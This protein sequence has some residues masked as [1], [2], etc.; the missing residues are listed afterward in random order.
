MYRR[1]DCFKLHYMYHSIL[2]VS[3]ICMYIFA[4]IILYVHVFICTITLYIHVHVYT[5]NI[6]TCMY[7]YIEH[8]SAQ[9]R[10]SHN[11]EHVHITTLNSAT[12]QPQWLRKSSLHNVLQCDLHVQWNLFLKR[13]HWDQEISS[14]QGKK[15]I[16]YLC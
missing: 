5:E 6:Y 15:C 12:K 9:E 10:A 13:H 11:Y 3:C 2:T 4:C 16:Y 1:I 8:Y 7:M 14:L